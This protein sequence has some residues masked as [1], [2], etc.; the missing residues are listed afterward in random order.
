[1]RERITTL[2]C[3]LGAL[4][5]FVTLF[6]RGPMELPRSAPPTT[7]ERGD[8]GLLAA[9][10]WLER[11]GIRTVSLRE[12]FDA[13]EK[14]RDLPAAG[15]LL[16]ISIPVVNAFKTA[17][18]RSLDRWVR[19]GNTLLL[20]AALSDRPAWSGLAAVHADLKALSGLEFVLAKRQPL[21]S[22][23]AD[24]AAG[25]APQGSRQQLALQQLAQPLRST[26]IANRPHPYLTGVNS[27]LALSDYPH[28]VWE[29][30]VP[31]AGFVL[32]LAHQRE[33]GEGVL[34]LRPAGNGAIIVSAFSSL[35]SNRALGLAENARLLANIVTA[36]LRPGGAVVFD[37]SHQGLTASYDPA[38]FY[39][40]R[41]L[42]ATLG[43]LVAVWLSWVLGSTRLRPATERARAPREAELVRVT[44][45][46][47]ARVLRP[48]AAARRL[49]EQFFLR[50][51]RL[52]GDSG[53]AAPPWEWLEKHPRLSADAVRQLREWYADAYSERRI[54]LQR[55]HNL[56]VRTE[57]QLAA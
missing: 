21:S 51:Q 54:P 37:D 48:A 32:A 25:S 47:L 40:D 8:D 28:S 17:E 6:L 23:P 44:G 2:L 1:V 19:A 20:L 14:R 10:D 35:F 15:N 24:P 46:F 49:F 9:R 45:L 5:V 33:L 18:M 50:L 16:I 29:V 43:V 56:I 41:R 11:E 38:K 57:R 55:L 36:S 12:R 22:A 53:A 3:A 7:S 42:Y 39:R 31:R 27:A 52:T 34:W 26:L 30:T 13:L 4:L